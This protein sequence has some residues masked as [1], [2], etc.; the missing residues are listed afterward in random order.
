MLSLHRIAFPLAC[1]LVLALVGCEGMTAVS[2]ADLQVIDIERFLELRGDEDAAL[3]VVDVRPAEA[4]E[5]AHIPGAINIPLPQLTAQH[6]SLINAQH[7]VVYGKDW[8]SLLSPAAAKKLIALGY[9]NVYDL[10]GGLKQWRLKGHAVE[11]VEPKGE[12]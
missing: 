5:E 8:D 1:C 3:V 4:F 9:R 2:D 12:E 10:R 7:I 11:T 6:P